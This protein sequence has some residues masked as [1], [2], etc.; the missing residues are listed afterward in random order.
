MILIDTPR[1]IWQ[2]NP[3]TNHE[4]QGLKIFARVATSL[5]A[6]SWPNRQILP[7]FNHLLELFEA[8]RK[9]TSGKKETQLLVRSSN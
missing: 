3:K 9:P 4:R 5:M 6:K 7:G 1:F 8:Q 2:D